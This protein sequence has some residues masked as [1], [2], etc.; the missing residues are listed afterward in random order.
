VIKSFNADSSVNACIDPQKKDKGIQ[1][2]SSA[3]HYLPRPEGVTAFAT[4]FSVRFGTRREEAE[5]LEWRLQPLSIRSRNRP[6][7]HGISRINCSHSPASLPI[8]ICQFGTSRR[9]AEPAAKAAATFSGRAGERKVKE[10]GFGF[11]RRLHARP[12]VILAT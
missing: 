3:A 11:S 1:N 8:C 6:G 12:T 9:G 2:H 7:K 4:T 10:S 5:T